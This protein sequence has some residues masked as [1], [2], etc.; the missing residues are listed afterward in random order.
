MSKRY[1]KPKDYTKPLKNVRQERFCQEY[2]ISC[3]KTKAAKKAGYKK[4]RQQGSRMTGQ[5]DVESRLDFLRS[6]IA[7]KCQITTEKVVSNIIDTHRRAKEAGDEY[8]AELKASDMLMRH[9]GGYEKDNAQTQIAN[10]KPLTE[11]ELKER[12]KA[13]EAAGNGIDHSS[14]G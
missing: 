4:P 2:L 7:E 12:L 6:K 11:A 9:T 1:L 8:N 14:I 5:L 10:K 3:D 13:I